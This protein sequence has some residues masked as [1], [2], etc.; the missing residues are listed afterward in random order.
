M[1]PSAHLSR[2]KRIDVLVFDDCS[3]SRA[4]T[5]AAL[6]GSGLRVEGVGT[7]LEATRAMLRNE[8]RVVVVDAD[9]RGIDCDRLVSLLRGVDR[10]ESLRIVM[11]SAERG[12][13]L[14]R[15]A[16]SASAD[17]VYVKSD[18]LAVLVDL[19]RD[20]LALPP[21]S[22]TRRRPEGLG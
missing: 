19:V 18:D 7:A 4:Q 17:A 1:S 11:T 5:V 21:A 10:L 16:A 14:E 2:P 6:E 22:G 3:V 13:T 9:A 8:A 15:V 12:A 20:Q